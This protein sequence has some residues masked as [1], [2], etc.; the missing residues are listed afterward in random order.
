M[1]SVK[2]QVLALTDWSDEQKGKAIVNLTGDN[3][4]LLKNFP[5]AVLKAALQEL[6]AKSKFHETPECCACSPFPW[7]SYQVPAPVTILTH[8]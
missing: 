4:L 3:V 1:E 8:S 7:D 2:Q 6:L 5:D